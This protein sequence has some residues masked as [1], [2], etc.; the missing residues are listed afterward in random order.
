[1]IVRVL[2]CASFFTLGFTAQAVAKGCK[3]L[4]RRPQVFIKGKSAVRRG[5]GLNY[6]VSTFLSKGRCAPFTEV[7]IDREWVLVD[8][9][10]VLG[11]VPRS[12][13]SSASQKTIAKAGAGDSAPVGSGQ[14][15]GFV[16]AVTQIQV[17]R[18]PTKDAPPKALLPE[19][20][21]FL[22][23]A[24]S[25]DSEWI[26]VRDERGD[27][28]WVRR[29]QLKGEALKD[30]PIFT[31]DTDPTKGTGNI[32]GGFRSGGGGAASPSPGGFSLGIS[33]PGPTRSAD[34]VTFI[35]QVYGAA[36]IPVHSLV[37]DSVQN[38]HSY[39]LTAFAA[40]GGIEVQVTDIGPVSVRAAYQLG[41]LSNLKA[42]DNEVNALSGMQHDAQI[43]IG[44]SLGLDSLLITPELGYHFGLFDFAQE[45]PTPEGQPRRRFISSQSHMG[46]AGVKLDYFVSSS[47]ALEADGAVML[48]GTI[49]GPELVR[50]GTPG[51][52]VGGVAGIGGQ[53]IV[54]D[55]VGIFF[56]YSANYRKTGFEGPAA[57]DPS[58]TQSTLT[59]FSHGL[60]V[61]AMF[62]WAPN[63]PNRSDG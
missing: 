36:L 50:L 60:L 55:S 61:G 39:D 58:I 30:L 62:F 31:G 47:F 51:L 28:G 35:T 1:M 41:V 29:E 34:T 5:P 45:L 63:S 32:G 53:L 2:A 23:L 43:R 14:E 15:R 8:V 6:P 11:W 22:P 26:E 9:K 7:S 17:K 56:R 33:A 54:G 19:G 4:G 46:M 40:G 49:E 20:T 24:R 44:L 12:K 57:L 18:Q 52:T 38:V 16:E 59:D 13:L 42:E 25:A 27:V 21:K 3:R 10:S 48:G 37:S